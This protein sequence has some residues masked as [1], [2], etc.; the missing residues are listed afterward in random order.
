MQYQ[1]ITNF[2]DK[3]PDQLSKFRTKNQVEINDESRR[4]YNTNAQ[5]KL[6]KTM[7][8]SSLCDYSDVYILIAIY[9]KAAADTDANNTNTKVIFKDCA[10]FTDYMSESINTQVDNAKYID[11]V[12][13]MQNIAIVIQK[14]LGAYGNTAKIHQ[15]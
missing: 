12:M 5:I 2:L 3:T 4:T 14:H 8:K 10:P 11:I 6:K 1:K 7:L 15:L 13:P 9:N